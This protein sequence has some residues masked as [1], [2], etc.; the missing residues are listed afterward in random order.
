MHEQP[1]PSV[2]SPAP[3]ISGACFALRRRDYFAIDGMDE[4]Y[5][6]H[7][8]DVDF[9]LRFMQAGGAVLF[10]PDVVVTHYKSSSR[11]STLRVEFR[12]ARSLNL[13][14][15]RHFSNAYPRGFLPL[16]GALVWTAFAARGAVGA[17]RAAVHA[18][19]RVGLRGA[20]RARA[21]FRRRA[22]R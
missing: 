1:C 5:F 9:C 18:F 17:A 11:V 3:T 6:L 19:R 8:E 21:I 10:D 13:Y 20:R 7:V 2:V 15:R 12:K 14:F 22:Q 16:V 4:R